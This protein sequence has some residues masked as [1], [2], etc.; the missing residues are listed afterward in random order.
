MPLN[1]INS[2]NGW[3][4]K[5]NLKIDKK[6]NFTIIYKKIK[7][8]FSGTLGFRHIIYVY[9][10]NKLNIKNYAIMRYVFFNIIMLW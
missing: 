7:K 9:F 10:K 5:I 8:T 3:I 1:T 2:N 4:Y 6:N